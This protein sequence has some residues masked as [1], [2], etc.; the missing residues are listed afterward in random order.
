MDQNWPVPCPHEGD[1]KACD[2]CWA[3]HQDAVPYCT[4]DEYKRK[5]H[6][7]VMLVK[8]ASVHFRKQFINEVREWQKTGHSVRQLIFRLKTMPL[9]YPY[10]DKDR[11][12]E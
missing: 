12:V 1:E 4:S 6:E 11:S 10:E 2:N 5:I 9:E 8:D 3:S 7:R